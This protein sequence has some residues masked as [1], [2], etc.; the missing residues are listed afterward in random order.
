MT[1]IAVAGATGRIGRPIV[2]LLEADGHE[3]VPIA[4]SLG[5]DV[6][7]GEG[8]AEALEG[9]EVIVDAATGPSPDEQQA[10]E[11]FTKSARNLLEAG[12]GARRIVLVSIIGIDRLSGGYQAAKLTQEEAYRNGP[13]PVRIVRASQFHEFIGVVMGW[14]R[15]GDVSYF[16]EMLTQPVLA[17]AA[18]EKVAELA[19]SDADG[20]EIV[21]VAGPR[22]ERAAELARLI[23]DRRGDGLR[24]EEVNDRSPDSARIAAGALLP[25]P[26]ATLTGP[27]FAEWLQTADA[28]AVLSA[29]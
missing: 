18:A 14:T 7:T 4:R 17:A 1:K 16:P 23:A 20:P 9:V 29:S 24:V 2:E 28:E 13:I 22:E 12:A 5:V 10:T 6:I 19:G 8:L 27:T 26:G 21:E 15:Q 25:G 3:V 11:F